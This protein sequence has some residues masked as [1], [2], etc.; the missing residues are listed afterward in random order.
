MDSL[1]RFNETSLPDKKAFYSGLYMEDT[2]DVDHRH[3][4]NVVKKFSLKYL[5]DY[6]DL[7]VQSDT[8]QL[9]DIFKNFRNECL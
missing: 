5:G 7:Y 2:S 4:K 3:A 6:H 8:I 1:G 9:C